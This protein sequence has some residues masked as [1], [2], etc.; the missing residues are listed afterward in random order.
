MDPLLTIIE[1]ISHS[2]LYFLIYLFC[3][4]L[5]FPALS[6]A[7]LDPRAH[8]HPITM[9]AHYWI[10]N[11]ERLRRRECNDQRY[12]S[13]S[14]ELTEIDRKILSFI[15]YDPENATCLETFNI[16]KKKTRCVFAKQAK[17]WGCCD[18]KDNN[19][20]GKNYVLIQSKPLHSCNICV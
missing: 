3:N 5:I 19:S 18:W 12:S 4:V 14:D 17:L 7:L 16:V 6:F 1:I 2:C 11:T 13:L 9:M 20:L 8:F 15:T 10:G